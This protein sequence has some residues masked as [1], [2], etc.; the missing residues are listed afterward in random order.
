MKENVLDVLMYLFE[1]YVDEETDIEPDRIQLQDKLL[2]AGFPGEEIDK[3]FDW[4]ENL[5]GQEPPMGGIVNGTALRVY[6]EKESERLDARARGFLLFL[7]QN[8]VLEAATRELVLDRIM[9]LEAEDISLDQLKWVTLM[10][11]F[12]QPDQEAAYT[13]LENM[14]FDTPPEYLH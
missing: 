7:E 11:L 13:W 3:A 9:D 5:A 14:M 8:G 4:L 6:T 2:E 1:N 12:N 10:V